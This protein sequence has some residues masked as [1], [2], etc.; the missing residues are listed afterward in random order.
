MEQPKPKDSGLGGTGDYLG[1]LQDSSLVAAGE[2]E[3]RQ[4]RGVSAGG[5]EGHTNKRRSA[6]PEAAGLR[7]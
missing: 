2:K 4:R 3:G 1:V 5:T 7:P 6:L